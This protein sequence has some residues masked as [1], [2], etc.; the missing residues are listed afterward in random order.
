MPLKNIFIAALVLF[1]IALGAPAKQMPSTQKARLTNSASFPQIAPE[2]NVGIYEIP[3]SSTATRTPT[4]KDEQH[5]YQVIKVVDGDTI[6]VEMNGKTVTIRL[7][8]LD[9]PETV[10]PVRSRSPQGDSSTRVAGA[11]FN[12]VNSRKPV[13]CFGQQASDKAKE[14]LTGKNV[15]LETDPSQG[16][17]DKYGRMLAYV[18]LPDGTNLNEM[19][20]AEGFGHE[21]T[22]NLPYKYQKE[23][24][25]AETTARERKVGLWAAGACAP[26]AAVTTTPIAT[27]TPAS[28]GSYDCSHNVYNCSSFKTQAEA[29]HVFELCG[30]DANDIHKLDRD[31]DGKVCE[32][33]P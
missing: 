3:T 30:G 20:I 31:G 15:R 23:F 28:S 8:G 32:S 13:Q 29:Q 14:V 18:F 19:M 26:A 11:S 10:A 5:F 9:T 33:L 6:A 2:A 12:G 17:L 25:T 7:I 22:Y 4:S 1:L 21:Y 24:K 27:I 16:N